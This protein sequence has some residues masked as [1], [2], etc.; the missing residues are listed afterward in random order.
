MFVITKLHSKTM[1]FKTLKLHRGEIAIYAFSGLI[2]GFLLTI[3][4]VYVL[5]LVHYQFNFIY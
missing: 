4:F 3:L 2:S 5:K 1:L